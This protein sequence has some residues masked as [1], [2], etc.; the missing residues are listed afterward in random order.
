MAFVTE[1]GK[2]GAPTV[3]IKVDAKAAERFIDDSREPVE[4]M[5]ESSNSKGP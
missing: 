4:E 3:T 2:K 5:K 1:R